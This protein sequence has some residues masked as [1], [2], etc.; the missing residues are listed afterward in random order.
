[1]PTE[2]ASPITPAQ[3]TAPGPAGAAAAPSW[4][5]RWLLN[6]WHLWALL[7]LTAIGAALRFYRLERPPIWFDEALTYGRVCGSW[8]ELWERLQDAGFMP[9]HY[10]VYWWLGQHVYLT[11][12][13]M[14]FIPALCGILTIP[15][16]YFLGRQL[17]SKRVSLA[18]ALLA[19]TSAYYLAFSRDAK[20]YM[21]TWFAVTLATGCLLW[22]TR[23][24]RWWVWILV[25]L[26]WVLAGALS[27]WVNANSLIVLALMPLM[28][29]AMLRRPW[30][31]VVL[32][33]VFFTIGA[34][35]IGYGPYW[36]YTSFNKW[37]K[38]TGIAPGV[39]SDAQDEDRINWNASGLTWIPIFHDGRDGFQMA[40]HSASS[41]LLGWEWPQH[42]EFHEKGPEGT[43]IIP[44]WTLTL[45]MSVM[46]AVALAL[47]VGL[48]PWPQRW[49]GTTA[50]DPPPEP[51]WRTAF[52][53]GAW[54]LLPTYGF[55]CRSFVNWVS[56][57]YWPGNVWNFRG[58]GWG[59]VGILGAAG[60]VAWLMDLGRWLARLP[61]MLLSLGLAATLAWAVIAA[62]AAWFTRWALLV[63]NPWISLPA[64]ILLPACLWYF[65]GATWRQRLG[66]A[67]AVL[68]ILAILWGLCWGVHLGC[69]QWYAQAEK[70]PHF[71][72]LAVWWPRYLGVVLPAFWLGVAALLMRLPSWPLRWTVIL[73]LVALNV[74]TFL[75]RIQLSTDPPWNI[76]AQDVWDAQASHGHELTTGYEADEHGGLG[77]WQ[78]QSELRSPEG[79]YY[80]CMAGHLSPTVAEFGGR[81]NPPMLR[82]RW[83][84]LARLGIRVR[85]DARLDKIIIW[86]R[87]GAVP[88]PVLIDP[89]V[90]LKHLGPGWVLQQDHLQRVRQHFS[91]TSRE[92]NWQEREWLR[93]MVFVRAA[94]ATRP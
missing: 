59:W 83:L 77:P 53:L 74:G 16:T 51:W 14:R 3:E 42:M 72:W 1:M 8:K 11:P 5:R 30:W 37:A 32:V 70:A 50:K 66:R 22:W 15:A 45:Y 67:T 46:E 20:M 49:R 73:G 82:T 47:L 94:A 25:W 31:R 43:Y 68:G 86:E 88:N 85:R 76:I 10:I 4:R 81:L 55:Y 56:P 78:P 39:T 91:R 26:G 23:T 52:L 87:H 28:V 89:S 41:F 84:P 35:A 60:G 33:V 92:W 29:L 7:G 75:A 48:M 62:R 61:V 18:A 34:T 21:D 24:R 69:L 2:A 12:F 40:R 36:Y 54:L 65:A 79:R 58:W 90:Y 80:W 38:R 44:R 6:P 93:R 13:W 71:Q 17:L 19:C 57:L 9:L 27:V 64:A 63:Q